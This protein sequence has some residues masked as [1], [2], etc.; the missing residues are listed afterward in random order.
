M[1]SKSEDWSRK[2][3]VDE[4]VEPP[5]LS[6]CG[7]TENDEL[8]H[9]T[10]ECFNHPKE[11]PRRIRE[12]TMAVCIL[13]RKESP[14]YYEHDGPIWVVDGVCC[15]QCP[16]ASL[17]ERADKENPIAVVEGVLQH[18]DNCLVLDPRCVWDLHIPTDAVTNV[19][20]NSE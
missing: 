16:A 4:I 12:G 11:Y 2:Q 13:E 6:R 9:E 1:S 20:S 19:S 8:P 10:C 17:Y 5:F 15:D 18:G 3:F 7:L 14:E